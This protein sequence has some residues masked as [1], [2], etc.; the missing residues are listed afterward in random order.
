MRHIFVI[1]KTAFLR[2]NN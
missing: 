2:I 1:A